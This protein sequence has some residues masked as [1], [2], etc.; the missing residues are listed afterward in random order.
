MPERWGTR[1]A[2]ASAAVDAPSEITDAIAGVAGG[3]HDI[4]LFHSS[5]DHKLWVQVSRIE[6]EDRL[7]L[8][9]V[10][11]EYVGRHQQ[12]ASGVNERLATLGWGADQGAD[13]TRWESASTDGERTA[14]AQ[15]VWATL[16]EAYGH[17]ASTAPVSEFP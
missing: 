15:V 12:L 8:E 10:S 11:D 5:L 6:G 7:L 2:L 14:L 13:Y 4:A 1:R 9:A 17:D 16:I 3:E